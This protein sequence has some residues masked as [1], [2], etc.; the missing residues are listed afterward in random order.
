MFILKFGEKYEIL[1]TPCLLEQE[2]I[3]IANTLVF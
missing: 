1:Q 2:I 3:Y